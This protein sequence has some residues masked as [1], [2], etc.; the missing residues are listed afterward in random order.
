M[1]LQIL[2]VI[3]PHSKKNVCYLSV[4]ITINGN[5]RLH[6]SH[7]LSKPTRGQDTRRN[8]VIII[9]YLLNFYSYLQITNVYSERPKQK[10]GDIEM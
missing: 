5:H 10:G 8:T 9:F 6:V 4:E 1:V 2:T 3:D 7:L